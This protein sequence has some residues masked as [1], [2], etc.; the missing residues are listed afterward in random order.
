MLIRRIALG[1]S[2]YI[3]EDLAGH[4]E[5]VVVCDGGDECGGGE[6]LV[7]GGGAS[8]GGGGGGERLLK[9]DEM[10]LRDVLDGDGDEGGRYGVQEK[11][12]GSILFL[13]ELSKGI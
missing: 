1:V 10:E 13:F 2:N 3:R 7:H 12:F 9:E 6:R 8:G 11:F 4:H 5:L